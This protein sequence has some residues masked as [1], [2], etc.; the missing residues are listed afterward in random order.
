MLREGY[1][2]VWAEEAFPSE[3]E[4]SFTPREGYPP[5]GMSGEILLE[6]GEG[7]RGESHPD[8]MSGE[9][10]LGDTDVGR[11]KRRDT[12]ASGEACEEEAWVEEDAASHCATTSDQGHAH[13]A[14]SDAGVDAARRTQSSTSTSV[15]MDETDETGHE[16]EGHIWVSYECGQTDSP[17]G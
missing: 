12:A 3:R 16:K 1:G 7:R 5:N 14:T 13:S 9:I 4:V 6:G 11:G 17:M 15:D 2:E 10:P 8:G